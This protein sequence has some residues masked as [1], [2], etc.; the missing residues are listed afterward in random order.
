MFTDSA[1][2]SIPAESEGAVPPPSPG[3]VPRAFKRRAPSSLLTSQLGVETSEFIDES[4]LIFSGLA[5]D[6]RIR[7][8]QHPWKSLDSKFVWKAPFHLASAP[9]SVPYV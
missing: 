2:A 6:G 9:R 3:G 5:D 4:R 8:P 1:L 7:R